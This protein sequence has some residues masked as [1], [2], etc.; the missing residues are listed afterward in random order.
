MSWYQGRSHITPGVQVLPPG[1]LKTNRIKGNRSTKSHP[2]KFLLKSELWIGLWFIKNACWK[3]FYT[4]KLMG[5]NPLR[6]SIRL[7]L[8][9]EKI[10]GSAPDW[11]VAR[12][13]EAVASK[14]ALKKAQWLW[15]HVPL[16]VRRMMKTEYINMRW[17]GKSLSGC[18]SGRSASSG[19]INGGGWPLPLE[20]KNHVII[21]FTDCRWDA[22]SV[23]PSI[24]LELN[25]NDEMM[26][27]I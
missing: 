7:R 6:Y 17:D 11:Y 3:F 13:E 12:T 23:C 1:K 21:A 24:N 14:M 15:G 19:R 8:H 18:N 20:S 10:P 16:C 25:A 27:L 9:L 2:E 26:G 5:F 22:F 4:D